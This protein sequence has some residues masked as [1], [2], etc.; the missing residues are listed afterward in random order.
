[1]K[2]VFNRM[3]NLSSHQDEKGNLV[4][5]LYHEAWIA[6]DIAKDLAAVEFERSGRVAPERHTKILDDAFT[7]AKAFMDRFECEGGL[8][9]HVENTIIEATDIKD[10][11]KQLREDIEDAQRATEALVR[12]L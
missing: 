1:M 3:L 2:K 8:I 5:I 7:F 11:L 12:K 10:R 9:Q 6:W 4:P